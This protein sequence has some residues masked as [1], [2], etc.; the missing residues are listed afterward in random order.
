MAQEKE[1]PV[2]VLI[3]N[4]KVWDGT[5]DETIDADVLLEANI[6]KQVA[7]GIKAPNANVID[8][9]GGVVT[10]GLIDMHQHLLL[11]GGTSAGSYYK[12]A[13]VQGAHA[14][15]A[16]QY[17]LMQGFTTVRDIAGNS[18]GLKKDVNSGILPGPRI[19]TSGGPISPTGGHGDWGSVNDGMYTEDYQEKN[20][21]T[22]VVDGKAEVMKAA[23]HNLRGGADFIKIMA[24]GGVASVFDPLEIIEFSKEEVEAIVEVCNEYRTY[25]AVHSYHDDSYNQLLDAGVKCFEHGFLITEPVAK[26]MA[27]KG[28]W[29]SWQPFGS[30]TTFAGDFPAWFT[31][32]MRR[33]G[34]KVFEGAVTAPKLMKKHGVKMFLGSDMFGWDNWHNA[35]INI[36]VPMTMP[37]MPFTDLDCMKMATSL[38]GQALRELTGPALDPFK[39]AKL[40]VVE[41]GAWGDVLIWKGDPT[42]DIMLLKDQNNLQVI[43]KD[44]KMYKNLTVA[45]TDPSYRGNLRPSGH[46]FTVPKSE[47]NSVE[48]WMK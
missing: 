33:K 29:W 1:A 43:I 46:S 9:K 3:T 7:K 12:D 19:Y 41:E 48:E 23:R 28:V 22:Y 40:G 38:P 47:V 25:A 45:E 8:G 30:Y 20:W 21:N 34:A 39:D 37:D 26:R 35:I 10:P 15:R 16:A 44:G 13:Y 32:D 5:S 31:P 42:K 18:R 14:S 36:T 6:I 17:L 4:V 11:N 27:E 2:Q 24:G